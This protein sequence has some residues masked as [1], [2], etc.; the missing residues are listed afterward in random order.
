MP[1]DMADGQIFPDAIAR[2]DEKH[3]ARLAQHQLKTGDIVFSRRGDVSRFAV[4][5]AKEEGWL[6]GTG[7]IRIR[8]NCPGIDTGYLRRFLQ[9]E[10]VG[11]WLLH[12]AKGVTMPNLNTQVIR[13][14]PFAYPPLDEQRRIATIL[15][16]ADGLRRKRREAIQKVDHLKSTLFETMF[17][18]ASAQIF[19]LGS[20]NELTS[21]TQYGTSSKAGDAGQYP[22]LRMGNITYDGEIDTADLK[23]LDLSATDLAKY[24]VAPGDILFNRTNS[25]DLVGKTAVVHELTRTY[26]FA[27]YLI[28]LRVNERADP[29]FVAGY[30]NSRRGKV[31]LRGMCKAII[32]MA[33][34]NAQELRGIPIRIPPLELQ[35]AFA[36]RVVE[37]DKLKEHHRAHLVELDALFASLQYRAFRGE[38]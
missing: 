1:Q 27:G 15:D 24:T 14:I 8:L 6:C 36:A 23:Y 29:E 4:V 22:I 9:Q 2:V 12:N 19:P 7:S 30:L 5:S 31:V 25:P 10:A 32:G 38:L 34:I 18:D 3:V 17:L 28:R 33:N 16:Q 26:A 37:I 13:A 21:S 20:I 35:H 11:A